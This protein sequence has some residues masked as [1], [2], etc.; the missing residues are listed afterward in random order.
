MVRE[1]FAADIEAADRRL[2]RS[3]LDQGCNSRMG[4]S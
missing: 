4:V 1:E 3:S 2:K